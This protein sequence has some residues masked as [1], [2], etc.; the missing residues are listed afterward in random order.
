MVRVIN[1][2][3]T[4]D[5]DQFNNKMA[6]GWSNNATRALLAIWGEENIQEQLD[7]V[8]R[9]RDIYEKISNCLSEQGFE[10]TWKQCRTKIKNLTQRYRKVSAFSFRCVFKEL[11]IYSL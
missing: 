5:Y 10:Y 1:V 9:N 11:I 6:T 8:A 7:G 3:F 2:Y 4:R